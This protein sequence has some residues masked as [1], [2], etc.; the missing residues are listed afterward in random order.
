MVIDTFVLSGAVKLF[1]EQIVP[2]LRF[3]HHTMLAHHSVKTNQHKELADTIRKVWTA[4]QYSSPAGKQRLRKLYEVDLL[5]VSQARVEAG[6]PV[7]P[8]FDELVPF[9]AQA[10]QRITEVDNN[11]VLVVN[12]DKDIEQQTLDFDKH[13]TWRILV[14]GSKLSRGFTVEGLTVT[15]FRRATNMS[16]SLAQMGRWF[17]FRNGYKDLVRLFIARRAKFGAKEVDLYE[18][19]AGVAMDESAFRQQLQMYAEWDGDKPRVLPAQ[20]P[21]LVTQ[22]LP[23]LKPVARNKMFN[24]VLEEQAQAEFKPTGYPN[25]VD[26][27]HANFD[28]WRPVLQ[29]VSDTAMVSSGGAVDYPA[30]LGIVSAREVIDRISESIYLPGYR[31]STVLPSVRFLE[32]I[33]AEGLLEDFLVVSPQPAKGTSLESIHDVGQRRIIVRSRRANRGGLFGE[34]TD[35]K[36]RPAVQELIAGGSDS[37]LSSMRTTMRGALILYLMRDKDP[38]YEAK[39]KPKRQ[40]SDPEYGVVVAWTVFPPQ[41]AVAGHR[42]RISFRVR[43]PD[44]SDLPVVDVPA[45]SSVG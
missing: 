7:A 33:L 37:S 9:I 22:H 10:I 20:I 1:R 28:L 44:Q 40:P 13:S 17:G 39:P 31:E 29:E 36:H 11:P 30:L 35:P 34:I 41:T 4:S 25:H 3:R 24:A 18:A 6:I 26:Q 14:G 23:W 38:Q 12:S 32:R 5:P 43:N 15:Y 2:S 21:P 45:G 8:P 16:S 42:G 27:M 19:F